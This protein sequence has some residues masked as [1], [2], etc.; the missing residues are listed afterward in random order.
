MTRKSKLNPSHSH[1][2]VT[3]ESF[4]KDPLICG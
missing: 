2:E 4:R 3:I 1:E